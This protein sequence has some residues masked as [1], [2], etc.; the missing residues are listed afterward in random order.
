MQAQHPG[1][2]PAAREVGARCTARTARWPTWGG[3][4]VLQLLDQQGLCLLGHLGFVE[5]MIGGQQKCLQR[6][7]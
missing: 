2:Q 7:N 6:T 1:V 3:F 4:K 5:G